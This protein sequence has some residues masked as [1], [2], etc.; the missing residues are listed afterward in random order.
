MVNR[1][2]HEIEITVIPSADG[3]PFLMG[4]YNSRCILK[5]LQILVRSQYTQTFQCNYKGGLEI[6]Q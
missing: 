2:R 4:D 6:Y 1:L 5:L 3:F